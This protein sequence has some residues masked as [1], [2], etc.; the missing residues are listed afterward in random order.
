MIQIKNT[1]LRDGK[2]IEIAGKNIVV[3]DLILLAAGDIIP[4]DCYI[5]ES[6]ELHVNESSLTGESYPVRKT[7]T[8]TEESATLEKRDNALWQGTNI[9]S[10]TASA[11]VVAT[12]SNTVFGSI[13]KSMGVV[14]ETAFE[15][16]IKEFGFF[17]MKITVVLSL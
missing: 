13:T 3:G 11:I 12:G 2:K 17:L 6:N 5:L 7:S 14:H 16:G 15:K 1:V 10:G 9:V 4:A 8:P